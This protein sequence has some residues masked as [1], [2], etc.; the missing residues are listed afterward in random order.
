MVVT[1]LDARDRFDELH[2]ALDPSH[3][4]CYT[5]DELRAACAQ[6]AF[7]VHDET[8]E[9]R[10]PVDIAITELSDGDRVI[11]AL[12]SEI[13]GGPPTGLDPVEADGSYSVLFV[14]DTVHTV[15]GG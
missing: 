6:D 14:M 4:R 9:F 2:R 15:R 8:L 13:A 12:R 11:D 1:D 3:V 5:P 7:P 10:A